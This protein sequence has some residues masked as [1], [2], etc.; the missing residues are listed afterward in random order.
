MHM[1]LNSMFKQSVGKYTNVRNT[2][3]AIYTNV[4]QVLD[5]MKNNKENA[6]ATH[7]EAKRRKIH[8]CKKNKI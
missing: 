4:C 6:H 3:D 1:Q 5:K 2:Q 7:F 8:K